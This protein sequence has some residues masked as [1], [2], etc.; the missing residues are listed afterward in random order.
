[1]TQYVKP[2]GSIRAKIEVGKL[3]EITKGLTPGAVR[4]WTNLVTDQVLLGLDIMEDMT[5]KPVVVCECVCRVGGGLTII[6]Q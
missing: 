3:E 4:Q 2:G 6:I 5:Q 1:M